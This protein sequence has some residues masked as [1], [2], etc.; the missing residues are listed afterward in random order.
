MFFF[1][2]KQKTAYEMRISDW[3]SDVCS[4]D[5][6]SGALKIHLRM[7]GYSSVT[8]GRERPQG[9][10]G[11]SCSALLQPCGARKIEIFGAGA[12]ERSVTISC[13]RDYLLHELGLDAG[14]YGGAR[15]R[16]R[17]SGGEGTGV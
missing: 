16:D 13:T 1:L 10:D 6:C 12:R 15:A 17:T 4:S 8:D 7:A 2:F 5:L 3:S 11:L 9:V 14:R